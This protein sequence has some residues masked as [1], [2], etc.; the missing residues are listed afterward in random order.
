MP[1]ASG[2][3][4]PEASRQE[5]RAGLSLPP[6][7]YISA[8]RSGQNETVGN[9]S[10]VGGK[11]EPPDTRESIILQSTINGVDHEYGADGRALPGN[12]EALYQNGPSASVQHRESSMRQRHARSP[13]RQ[14]PNGGKLAL[15]SGKRTSGNQEGSRYA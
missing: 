11:P 1:P 6:M 14:P 7:S 13:K 3:L 12:R 10:Y 9:M 2:P 5:E 15:V 8:V 4:N